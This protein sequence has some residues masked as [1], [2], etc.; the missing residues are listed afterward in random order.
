MTGRPSDLT[1]E[2]AKIDRLRALASELRVDGAGPFV[3]DAYRSDATPGVDERRTAER[4][5]ERTLRPALERLHDLLMANQ[6]HSLLV[7]LQG[8]D[9]SG[10]SGTIKHVGSALNPCST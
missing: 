6:Q 7:V 3:F 1:P 2:L 4:M 10:K 5:L 8:L 9:G